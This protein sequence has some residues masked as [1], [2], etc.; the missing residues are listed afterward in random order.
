MT[1]QEAAFLVEGQQVDETYLLSR[2]QLLFTKNGKPYGSLRL[3][4]RTGEV[5]ARLWERAEELLGTLEPGSAVRVQGRVEIYQ[6][7]AQMVLTGIAPDISSDPALFLPVSPVPLEELKEGLYQAVGWVENKHLKRLLKYLFVDES[8]FGQAFCNAPAAKNAHHAY[9]HGLL[10]HTIS[11]ARLARKVGDLYRDQL[12]PDI[13]VTGAL[14]HDIGKVEELTLGPPIDYTDQGR[15]EGH[16]V[17]GVRIFEA[18]A[19]R[20]KVFP[21]QMAM[22]L[23]HLILSHHGQYEFGSPKRP[24]TPEALALNFMDDLDAKL[25]IY[26]EVVK[27]H[28]DTGARWSSFNRLLERFLYLAPSHRQEEPSKEADLEPAPSCP[29]LFDRLGRGVEY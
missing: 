26:R 20:I 8:P 18:Q 17:L 5:E 4:D 23:R 10:E 6:G 3:A 14:I 29:S 21:P 11:V 7:Q 1:R 15:L 2:K 27:A 25:A 13:L 9:V 24:K 16:L 28:Q 19:S 22:E 12:N